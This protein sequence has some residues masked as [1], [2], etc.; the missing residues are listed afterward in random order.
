MDRLPSLI[1]QRLSCS[2]CYF[3]VPVPICM[4]KCPP[5]WT[6]T[7]PGFLEYSGRALVSENGYLPTCAWGVWSWL[8]MF[9]Y[10]SSCMIPF[11][12]FKNN[13]LEAWIHPKTK[14]QINRLVSLYSFVTNCVSFPVILHITPIS[15]SH[16]FQS[17]SEALFA[18]LSFAPSRL[19]WM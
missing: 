16:F 13:A 11:F 19:R 7:R 1:F 12:D 18:G 15:Q 8:C 2:F 17:C 14:L 5:C 10:S 6:D 3:A 9:C 4:R